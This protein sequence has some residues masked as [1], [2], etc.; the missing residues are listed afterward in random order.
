MIRFLLAGETVEIEALEADTTILNYLRD[1]R[2]LNGTKEGCASG[3]CG[4]CTVVTAQR[5]V[6][7]NLHYQPVNACIAPLAGVAGKQLITVEDLKDGETWHP[8]QRAMIECHGSQCGFCTPGF[9]MSMFALYHTEGDADR[10]AILEALGGNLCRCTGYRPIIE[11]AERALSARR[12]DQFSRLE[13]QT[14]EQLEQWADDPLVTPAL[15]GANTQY[16]RPH[17]AEAVAELLADHPNARIVAGGTD[18]WLEVTQ[19]LRTLPS[20]I[21]VCAANDLSQ[22]TVDSDG[23]RLAAG[24]THRD[25]QPPVLHDYP[26]L[27]ELIERFGSLQIRSQGTVVGNI[28][29]A[30]PIG[31]WPPVLLAL[32]ADLNLRS[33][34]GTRCIPI[35]EFF[36][37]YR[38]TALRPGEFIES[39]LL[40]RRAPDLFLRAYKI[41]KRYEDD[42]SSL[43]LVIALSLNGDT[44]SSARVACGG[45]AATPKRA[46]QCEAALRGMNLRDGS[47][48][49]AA[50]GLDSD[51]SPI[52]DA[53]ASASYRRA[54]AKNLL[55]RLQLEF[56]GDVATRARSELAEVSAHG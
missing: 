24:V 56:R 18:L 8:V 1:Q 50:E 46:A 37:A 7:G 12:P 36:I 51:F 27:A 29:N 14:L 53:R 34:A 35:D 15:L 25:S 13:P 16:F 30:S 10:H 40:P 19:N 38:K 4:A 26:E 11:A 22:I 42:I 44:V 48:D 20:L 23:I 21:D 6:D 43:C 52:S 33:I 3:D 31:D 9:V 45:M 5:T 55:T 41:S 39:V 17:S 2:R 32:T 49:S 54:V 28:A 47:M